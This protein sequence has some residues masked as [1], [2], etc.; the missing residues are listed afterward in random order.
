MQKFTLKRVA[1]LLLALV[2][3]ASITGCASGNAVS[4][5]VAPSDT[6]ASSAAA[7]SAAAPAERTKVNFWYL[8]GGD[9]AKIIEEIIAAYNKSQDKYEAVGLS[10]PDQQKI[11]TAIS[12]GQGPD[13]TD[14]FGGNIPK[15]ALQS[16]A[17]P[18]DDFIKAEN[19]DTSVYVDSAMQMMKFQ[20]KVYGL[21]LS[22]N[23]FALYY[24]KDLLDKA[25]IKEL[26]KTLEDLMK[27][28]EDT[29]KVEGG[30]VTQLG[31]PFV[32][33]S[34]WNYCFT[35]A[36]G[37]LFAD[38]DAKLTPDNAGFKT[39]LDY[40]AKEVKKFGSDPLNNYITSGVSKQYTAEDPFCKGTQVFRIDGPWFYNMAKT[41]GIN[42]DLMPLPGAASV[43]GTGYSMMDTSIMYIPSTAK[44][45]D[46]A[47]DFV[48]YIT[49]GEGSKLFVTKK[50]DLP[51]TKALAKDESIINM[52][53]AS[54]VYIDILNQNHCYALP[55]MEAGIEYD[56][57]IKMATESV[58]LG[59]SVD[60]AL[61][62][63][64]KD[65]A[66]LVK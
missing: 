57:A 12:G 38:K 44:N 35:Y 24:N 55:Q 27:M 56:K 23:V 14:D 63:I 61:T 42:F 4:S 47:W 64:K 9:E 30:V 34:Y 40:L 31:M 16:I 21:P 33:D 5:S 18:M 41:A 25:G 3:T 43:G 17:L 2:T 22:V 36:N 6:Q 29:T 66:A 58:R 50:G 20:D 1:A 7:S 51:P 32:T 54:K 46:G 49:S 62:K 10:T 26:P 13:V 8:W 52:T 65:T 37:G 48:K 39:T 45:K 19:F 28:G 60:E 15:Y 11:I 53:P 59:G